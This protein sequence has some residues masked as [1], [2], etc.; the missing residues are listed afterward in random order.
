M[1]VTS[2]IM[3]LY[4]ILILNYDSQDEKVKNDKQNIYR[5]I[6]MELCIIIVLPICYEHNDTIYIY[7]YSYL[8][9]YIF[10]F[11]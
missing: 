3:F 4:P 9:L 11:N 2:A 5:D 7:I 1:K 6:E 10:Q 8:F